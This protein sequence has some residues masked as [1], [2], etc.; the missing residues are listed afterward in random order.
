L[1]CFYLSNRFTLSTI[2]GRDLL[3]PR[4]QAERLGHMTDL[5]LGYLIRN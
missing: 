4:E 5:V 1:S 2:F 3:A